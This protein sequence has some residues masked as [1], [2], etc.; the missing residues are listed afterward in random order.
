M[1]YL[2]LSNKNEQTAEAQRLIS[3][4][5]C[6]EEKASIQKYTLCDPIYWSSG[7]DKIN[8]WGLE[9]K[10]NGYLDQSGIDC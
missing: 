6:W 5:L 2:L 1:G 9:V 4:T 3:Q 7:T 10:I 8:L